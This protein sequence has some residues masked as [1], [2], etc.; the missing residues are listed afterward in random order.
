MHSHFHFQEED[1]EEEEEST[2][3]EESPPRRRKKPK[4]DIE[5]PKKEKKG[6]SRSGDSRSREESTNAD[7]KKGGLSQ[8]LLGQRRCATEANERIKNVTQQEIHSGNDSSG[9]EDPGPGGERTSGRLRERRKMIS[10][11]AL[12]LAMQEVDEERERG[13]I[14]SVPKFELECQVC[15]KI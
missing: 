12:H 2:M 13:I 8:L 11:A 7:R 1:S 10:T 15:P 9:P 6:S 14:A 4:R 3:D 5:P